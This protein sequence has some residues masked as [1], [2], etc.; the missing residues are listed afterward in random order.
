MNTKKRMYFLQK[1]RLKIN[2]YIC[3]RNLYLKPMN[4]LLWASSSG[5]VNTFGS[6]WRRWLLF[7]KELRIPE[8]PFPPFSPRES[9]GE[10]NESCHEE[11]VLSANQKANVRLEAGGGKCTRFEIGKLAGAE[12]GARLLARVGADLVWGR[13]RDSGLPAKV[14]EVGAELGSS[15]RLLR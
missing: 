9:K 14:R 10:F 5:A 15:A 13:R 4:D 6:Q 8:C 2:I 1:I 11:P 12:S 3:S 7:R